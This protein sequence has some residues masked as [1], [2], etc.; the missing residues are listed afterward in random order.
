MS[1]GTNQDCVRFEDPIDPDVAA[2]R[3]GAGDGIYLDPAEAQAAQTAAALLHRVR[4]EAGRS[5][6]RESGSKGGGGTPWLS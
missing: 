3:Y 1:A 5:V 6:K 4:M 2:R